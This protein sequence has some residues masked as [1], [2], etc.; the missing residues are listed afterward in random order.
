[1]TLTTPLNS[2]GHSEGDKG[3]YTLILFS[4]LLS[5]LSLS[6][7]Q[8]CPKHI[9][10]GASLSLSYR[11][12]NEIESGRIELQSYSDESSLGWKTESK[13][14]QT[15][16]RSTTKTKHSEVERKKGTPWTEEEHR[17]IFWVV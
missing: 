16:F 10:F 6:L 15:S 14:S 11:F 4:S 8:I 17:Y 13:R 3:Q 12:A 7:S 9:S 5:S 1:M 2:V